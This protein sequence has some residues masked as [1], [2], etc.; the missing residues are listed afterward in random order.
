MTNMNTNALREGAGL[1]NW[2]RITY[3]C[4]IY[5]ISIRMGSLQGPCDLR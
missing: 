2:A 1:I 5:F 4:F 3:T